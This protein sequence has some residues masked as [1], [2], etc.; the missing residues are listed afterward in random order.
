M[1]E[2]EGE[3]DAML[4]SLQADVRGEGGIKTGGDGLVNE[5]IQLGGSGGV[6]GRFIIFA[7][8]EGGIR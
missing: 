8:S 4:S 5:N 6:S 2:T 3:K 7:I 1:L